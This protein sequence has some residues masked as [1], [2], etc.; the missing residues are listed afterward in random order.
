MKKK[1]SVHTLLKKR[2]HPLLSYAVLF[3]VGAIAVSSTGSFAGA[4]TENTTLI[5]APAPVRAAAVPAAPVDLDKLKTAATEFAAQLSIIRSQI[6][7]LEKYGRTP[8]PAL[9]NAL[10]QGDRLVANINEART[11]SELN[12]PDPAA[13]MQLIGAA[14]AA[15]SK[16]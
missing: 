3:G 12:D 1:K 6:A 10:D 14:I 9:M 4:N 15:A 5:P 11:P 16:F 7:E 8:S 2:L 13:K